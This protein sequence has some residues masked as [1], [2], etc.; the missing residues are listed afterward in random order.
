MVEALAQLAGVVVQSGRTVPLSDM[1]L[2]AVRQFKIL[3]T[4]QPGELMI[5][6]AKVDGVMGGLIQASGSISTES[7]TVIGTGAIVLTG[8][9]ESSVGSD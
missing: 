5:I 6:S 9:D 8:R 1:R 4:L 3:G 2:T 7:G